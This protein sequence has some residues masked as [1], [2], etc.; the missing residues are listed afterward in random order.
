[1]NLLGAAGGEAVSGTS[2]H[3]ETNDYATGELAVQC[4][5]EIDRRFGLMH[6]HSVGADTG[7]P[8]MHRTL[9]VCRFRNA[10]RRRHRLD[11]SKSSRFQCEMRE[12]YRCYA[13]GRRQTEGWAAKR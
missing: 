2:N 11:M 13:N 3:E 1:M 7:G 12:Q 10:A 4:T 8:A 5:V 6:F 9:E